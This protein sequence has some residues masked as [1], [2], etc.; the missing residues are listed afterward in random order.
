MST[1]CGLAALRRVVTG[2]DDAGQS[3]VLIDD[4]PRNA[5]VAAS[6]A[7]SRLVWST[8]SSP[9]SIALGPCED[10]GA[11]ILGTAPMPR[12]SRFAVVDIPPGV[13]GSM[14][15]TDTIDYV[16]VLSGVVDMVLDRGDVTMMAGDVMV[17]RGTNH[18]WVNR[19][20]T[21]ARIAFVLLDADPLPVGT[22]LHGLSSAQ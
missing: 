15:R 19:G 11:R 7:V 8:D 16:I 5:K 3:V 12:G 4:E 2:H 20:K 18:S 1:S 21:T 14:H 6:G 10:M 9:A 13:T 17:Q 22:A